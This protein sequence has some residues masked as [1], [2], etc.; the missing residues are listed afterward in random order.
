VVRFLKPEELG[1]TRI[2]STYVNYVQM[3]GC[4][5]LSSAVLTFVPRMGDPAVRRQWLKSTL[6]IV[7][8]ATAGFSLLAV[9]LSWHGL[10][11]SSA[12]TAF[13]FRWSLLGG[14]ATAATSIIISFYQ[15]ERAVKQL[16]GIQSVVRIAALAFCVA[17]AWVGGF[18]GY[19]IAGIVSPF[20]LLG[21]L[22]G[23]QSRTAVPLHK[24]M[25]P[26]GYMKV[27]GLA[28]IATLLWTA[29]RTADV[30]ILDRLV[31]NR[32]KFGCYS[33]ALSIST[34]VSIINATVQIVTVPYFSKR[35]ESGDWVLR[36]ARKWQIAGTLVCIG[37]SIL[38][39]T[40]VALLLKPIYGT[41]YTVAAYYLVPLLLAQCLLA[42][43]HIQAAAMGGIGLVKVNTTIGAIVVPI[44]VGISYFMAKKY[45]IE[46][47]IW[48]QVISAAFYAIVQSVWGWEI[49]SRRAR[50]QRPVMP[51]HVSV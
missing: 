8:G 47:A 9:W 49:L 36:N 42:T 45:G 44:S 39:I 22:I 38:I 16:A 46:G 18:E 51:T 32:V 29:G 3:L 6:L 35:H 27:A 26:E 7:L 31:T 28:M 41:A 5:G 33:L 25:L 30:V 48:G 2:I 13:W 10:L 34:I 17:G 19:I 23:N 43:F 12:H 20:I 24:L 4:L 14:M 37:V 1:E 50:G 21:S 40:G 15:A 11:M